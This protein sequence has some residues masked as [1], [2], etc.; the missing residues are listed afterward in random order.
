MKM[1]EETNR[2]ADQYLE[3]HPDLPPQ[4]RF[5]KWKDYKTTKEEMKAFI[6]LN[7]AMGLA[8]KPAEEEY[9]STYWLTA[10]EFSSVM[11]RNR[12]QLLKS[13]IHFNN[14]EERPRKDDPGY[15]PLFKIQPLIDICHPTY[16]TAYAP[17]KELS[18]DESMIR[19][20]GR[21]AFRQYMPKKPTKWGIKDFCLCEAKTGYCIKAMTYTG[22]IEIS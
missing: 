12:Y 5:R 9:W 8:S 17:R 6:A 15:N 21:I 3:K 11:P 14:N 18:V 1:T 19:F 4:S 16:L 10:L 13:F 20:K 2:Y 22:M 7:I